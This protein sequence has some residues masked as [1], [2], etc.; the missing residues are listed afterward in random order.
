MRQE[1]P[2]PKEVE[3][4][5][6]N[7]DQ[8]VNMV[9]MDSQDHRAAQDYGETLGPQVLQ[10]KLVFQEVL[11]GKEILGLQDLE[12]LQVLREALD[13]KETLG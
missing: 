5:K 11:D 2:A 10:D 6:E 7:V 13:R 8:M 1:S 12:D 3:G 4:Y 9:L